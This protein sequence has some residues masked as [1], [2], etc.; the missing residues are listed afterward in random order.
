MGGYKTCGA[1]RLYFTLAV[2][3]THTVVDFRIDDNDEVA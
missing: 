1:D 3:Q 2:P